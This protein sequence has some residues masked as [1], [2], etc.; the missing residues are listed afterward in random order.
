LTTL[1]FNGRVHSPAMPD[2]T[3]VAIRDGVIAWLGSDDVGRAQFPD[4]DRQDLDGGFVAPAFVDSHVHL[5]ATGLSIIGLDL[6]EA[7]SLEH[8]LKLVAEYAAAH[9]DGPI[10]AHGWDESGW[11]GRSAPTTADIDRVVGGR[12]VYLARVDVHS[13]AASTALRRATPGVEHAAGFHPDAPLSAD[14]HHLVR[15]AARDRLLPAQLDAARIAALDL[16]ASLG[17]VAVHECAG[18]EIGGLDDWHALRAIDSGIDIVGYW[19]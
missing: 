4:A 19:G 15:A 5:T 16:A 9:P 1:L 2:A 8:C 12:M 18:P 3:A 7:A 10:W 11:P 17:I 14:A 13:A 6:R